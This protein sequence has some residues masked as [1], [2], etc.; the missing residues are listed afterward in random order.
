MQQGSK[1]W[2]VSTVAAFAVIAAVAYVTLGQTAQ[3]AAQQGGAAAGT[4]S[5]QPTPKRDLTGVWMKRN[6]RSGLT[7]PQFDGATWTPGTP[8]PLTAWGVEERKKNRPNNSGEFLLHETNDPVLT[9]CYPPGTPR[10]YFHP[11]PFEF[12]QTPSSLL[13]IFE[14]DHTVRRMWTGRD[15]PSDP[16]PL[17]MGTS[18]GRWLD[19]QTFEAVTVGFNTK[20]WLDRAGAP[21]SDQL[22]VTERFRRVTFD[23]LELEVTMEDAVALEKPWVGKGFYELRPEW[24]LGEISCPGD[25]L[26]WPGA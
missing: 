21:H 5:A 24:E 18:V 23:T 11:Y 22:K 10:V 16:D 26:E 19:D 3:P 20:T 7:A 8:P 1:A 6:A 15:L 4:A 13:Q 12:V 14:Y 2:M 9:K 17:W 25:Y